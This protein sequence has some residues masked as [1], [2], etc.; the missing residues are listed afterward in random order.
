M[1]CEKKVLP[2]G[3]G[4][5]WAAGGLG[6][7]FRPEL[8]RCGRVTPWGVARRPAGTVAATG[9]PSLVAEA[10]YLHEGGECVPMWHYHFCYQDL[11]K[12]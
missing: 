1:F 12:N 4:T 3:G 11:Q 2:G 9:R 10:W 5:A 6:R 8:W 7:P